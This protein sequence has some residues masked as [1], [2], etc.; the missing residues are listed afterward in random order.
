MLLSNTREFVSLK[1]LYPKIWN[2]FRR[3]EEGLQWVIKVCNRERIKYTTD[4]QPV[5]YEGVDL[6]YR[7]EVINYN[8][9]Y[10]VKWPAW[11]ISSVQNKNK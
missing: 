8:L 1:D 7:V 11:K 2:F 10:L 6:G 9:L 4:F 5:S 3:N